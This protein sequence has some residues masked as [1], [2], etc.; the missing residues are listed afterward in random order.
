MCALAACE[1]RLSEMLVNPLECE[2]ESPEDATFYSMLVKGGY[3]AEKL[4]LGMVKAC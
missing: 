1:S 2:G 3:K 4:E